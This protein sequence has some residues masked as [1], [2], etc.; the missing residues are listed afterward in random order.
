[1]K[2]SVKTMI[3]KLLFNI[4]ILNFKLNVNVEQKF[5]LKISIQAMVTLYTNFSELIVFQH[6]AKLISHFYRGKVV[7]IRFQG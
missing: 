4:T 1:M 3:R 6:K 2:Q 5:L 7:P